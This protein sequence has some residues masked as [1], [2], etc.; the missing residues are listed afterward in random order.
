MKRQLVTLIAGLV[1]STASFAAA[2]IGVVDM[3]A[4]Q[5]SSQVTEINKQ[6][7]AQFQPEYKKLVQMNNSLQAQSNKLAQNASKMNAVEQA[8]A[9]QQFEADRKQLQSMASAYQRDFY[10][11]QS[12]A[13]NGLVAQVHKAAQ[14]VAEKQGLEFVLAKNAVL[15]ASNQTDVTGQILQELP[16]K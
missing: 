15:F 5:K 2:K 10:A 3:D 9:K 1:L 11:A 4:L 12:R 16:K 14:T 6:L 7:S 8:K 13:I